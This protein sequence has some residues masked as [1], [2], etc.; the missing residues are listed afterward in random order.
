MNKIQRLVAMVI[1]VVVLMIPTFRSAEAA[2][3]H[4]GNSYYLGV[5]F[6]CTNG[7]LVTLLDTQGA[8]FSTGVTA[9]LTSYPHDSDEPIEVVDTIPV[10]G[11]IGHEKLVATEHTRRYQP[12]DPDTYPAGRDI[13]WYD[14]EHITWQPRSPG[15]VV[16]VQR[17][18]IHGW[19]LVGRIMDCKLPKEEH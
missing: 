14:L 15:T 8:G 18:G 10:S 9:R 13:N 17:D 3:W 6:F 19:W 7:V 2:A 16:A 4:S 1:I 12:D 5:G 11:E